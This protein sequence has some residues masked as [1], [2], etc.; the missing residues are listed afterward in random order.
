MQVGLMAPQGWKGEY[1]GWPAAAPG[2]GPSSS[3]AQA[4]ALGFESLWVFDHF[5]TVPGPDRR[6][7]LRVV[8]GARRARD[9][10]RAGPPRPHG[11]VHGVPQ[12]G[13]HRQAVLDARRHQRRPVRARDRGRLEGRRVEGLR[14]RLP[15]ASA[16]GWARSATIS[17]SSPGCSAPG[18]ATVRGRVRPGP[19]RGQRPEGPPAA[20]HPD[21]HRRQRRA[22]HR[23]LRRQVRRRAQ[24]RVPRAGRDRRRAWPRS[25][26][27]ARPRAATPRRCGSRSTSATSRS[28]TPAPGAGRPPRRDSPRSAWTGSSASRRAGRRRSRRRPRSPTTAGRPACRSRP[29]RPRRPA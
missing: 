24:L 14:L 19:R 5:H 27:A 25:G 23:R 18:R 26:P 7:H 6:D 12:P 13:P 21:H 20:A 17:R 9:G 16:S 22:G 10:D 28:A 15:D 11:R 1:D 29:R 8:L 4:E 3:R 2:R